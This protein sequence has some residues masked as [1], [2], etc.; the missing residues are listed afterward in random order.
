MSLEIGLFRWLN[1]VVRNKLLAI[2]VLGLVFSG[3][4]HAG[5]VTEDVD[6]YEINEV[7][8]GRVVKSVGADSYQLQV[9]PG[10][11]VDMGSGNSDL[12]VFVNHYVEVTGQ[13][14]GTTLYVDEVRTVLEPVE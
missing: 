5:V 6:V 3:C 7:Y 11:I 2:F 10:E 14:S 8:E 1:E 9:G 13:F 12:S 4:T